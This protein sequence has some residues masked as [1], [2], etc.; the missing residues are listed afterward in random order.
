MYAA[1][2]NNDPTNANKTALR[3]L[4]NE[5]PALKEQLIE[6]TKDLLETRPSAMNESQ[7][8][9]LQTNLSLLGHYDYD[10]AGKTEIDGQIGRGSREAIAAFRDENGLTVP[11][12]MIAKTAE[13]EKSETKLARTFEREAAKPYIGMPRL[14]ASVRNLDPESF[15]TRD[16]YGLSQEA[17]EEAWRVT[18]KGE[19][20]IL[21]TGRLAEAA[22]K[23]TLCCRKHTMN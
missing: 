15:V 3:T 14:P 2:I 7:R 9:A 12:T 17:V 21:T 19:T 20:P 1:L 22:G 11:G 23:F 13:A 10:R 5:N 18:L 16:T 4:V 8:M 6:S